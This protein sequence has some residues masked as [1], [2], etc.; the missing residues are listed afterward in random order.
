MADKPVTV[1]LPEATIRHLQAL[2]LVDNGNLADQIRNAADVYVKHR[3]R[4]P[5]IEEKILEAQARQTDV[6]SELK[7]MVTSVGHARD[8]E[9]N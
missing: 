8:D 1:R 6:L 3:L 7:T 9:D 2:M 4:E 5:G